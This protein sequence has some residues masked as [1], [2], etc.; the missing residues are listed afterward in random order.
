M[1]LQKRKAWFVLVILGIFLVALEILHLSRQRRGLTSKKDKE[2]IV[3]RQH[4]F[5]VS[6]FQTQ[7]VVQD[8]NANVRQTKSFTLHFH[9]GS[10]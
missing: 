7:N 8:S 5:N 1:S 10:N 3:S 4:P 2:S 6:T 9:T